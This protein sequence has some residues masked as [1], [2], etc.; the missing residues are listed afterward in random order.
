MGEK[1][2]KSYDKARKSENINKLAT[3]SIDKKINS[4]QPKKYESNP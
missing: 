2:V 3:V 4:T 1:I